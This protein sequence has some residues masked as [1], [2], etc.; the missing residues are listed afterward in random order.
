MSEPYDICIIGHVTRDRIDVRGESRTIP[1]GTVYYSGMA[2][3]SL[4]A[5]VTV[6][7][8]ASERDCGKLLSDLHAFRCTSSL[9]EFEGNDRFRKRLSGS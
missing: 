8:K 9:L 1:G 3:S 6:L 7:T 5:S 2:L 4:G